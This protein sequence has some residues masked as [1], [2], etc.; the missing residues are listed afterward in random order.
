MESRISKNIRYLRKKNKLSQ[1]ELGGL[2]GK[3]ES[4][5][6]MWESSRRTPT[7]DTINKLSEIFQVDINTLVNGDLEAEQ[8]NI[9]GNTISNLR[10]K[11]GLS[12]D[13]LAKKL[14]IGRNTVIDWEKGNIQ[15]DREQE[16]VIA[17]FFHISKEYL[18]GIDEDWKLNYKKHLASINF[19]N[20]LEYGIYH[21]GYNSSNVIDEYI[22]DWYNKFINV[23]DEYP[24]LF[25]LDEIRSEVYSWLFAEEYP[26]EEHI[27]NALYHIEQ[28]THDIFEEGL[29]FD[30]D[31]LIVNETNTNKEARRRFDIET[32]DVTNDMRYYILTL[33]SRDIELT[34]YDIESS[35]ENFIEKHNYSSF[36]DE[37]GKAY[38]ALISKQL[39]EH[40]T[41]YEK[42]IKF[43]R[44]K[45]NAV[46]QLKNS[47]SNG[48]YNLFVHSIDEFKENVKQIRLDFPVEDRMSKFVDEEDAIIFILKCPQIYNYCSYNPNEYTNDQLLEKAKKILFAIELTMKDPNK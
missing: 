37:F 1:P 39:N 27:E 36:D 16:K 7:M 2:I 28:V 30:I 43:Y 32:E 48:F 12:V 42:D 18:H 41:E 25:T 21:Y 15:P 22:S 31:N 44:E 40:N 23:T 38:N 20:M 47:I 19:K 46:N 5:I 26:I 17:D 10:N 3:S 4:A 11:H 33:Y 8:N 9:V 35:H 13:L 14:N 34:L 24:N 6:Q 45:L 29:E